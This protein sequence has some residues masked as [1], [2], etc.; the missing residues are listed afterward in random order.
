M[1]LQITVFVTLQPHGVQ[2]LLFDHPTARLTYHSNPALSQNEAINRTD[3][4]VSGRI[5]RWQTIYVYLRAES[6]SRSRSSPP[7]AVICSLDAYLRRRAE[8]KLEGRSIWGLL[9]QTQIVGPVVLTK[10]ANDRVPRG[11]LYI[12][13]SMQY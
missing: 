9:L 5:A 2:A 1:E 6:V 4:H 12:G 13:N 3:V 7:D 10:E 11:R 8:G